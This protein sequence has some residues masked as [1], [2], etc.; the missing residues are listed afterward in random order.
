[1]YRG[2]IKCQSS[3]VCLQQVVCIVS[4]QP[5]VGDS[6]IVSSRPCCPR[7]PAAM[8]RFAGTDLATLYTARVHIRSFDDECKSLLMYSP[9]LCRFDM[10]MCSAAWVDHMA[11]FA[12]PHGNHFPHGSASVP[13]MKVRLARLKRTLRNLLSLRHGKQRGLRATWPG[14]APRLTNF[15]PD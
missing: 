13:V 11:A 6:R 9:S 14:S 12:W 15:Q 2:A 3:I 7:A 1:M 5:Q 10:H 8:V 4:W